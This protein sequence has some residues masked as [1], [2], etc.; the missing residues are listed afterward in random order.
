MSLKEHSEEEKE[1]LYI[2]VD[3]RGVAVDHV[4]VLDDDKVEP[5][6]TSL[7]ASCHSVLLAHRLQILTDFLSIS[8]ISL[9]LY[10]LFKL[11]FFL[12]L[13]LFFTLVSSLAKAPRPTRVVYA[14]TMAITSPTYLGCTP[15]PL[16]TPPMVHTELVTYGYVPIYIYVMS[17]ISIIDRFIN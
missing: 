11:I 17:C 15:K 10:S 2:D 12:L 4:G 8:T 1:S 6:T 7:A 16:H 14:L 9:T 5:A 13:L 3:L